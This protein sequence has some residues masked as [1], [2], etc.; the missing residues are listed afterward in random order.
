[1][2]FIYDAL[3]LRSSLEEFSVMSNPDGLTYVRNRP[4]ASEFRRDNLEDQVFST[5]DQSHFGDDQSHSL[6]A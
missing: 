4:V 6:S 1:M 3:D 5:Y 2:L